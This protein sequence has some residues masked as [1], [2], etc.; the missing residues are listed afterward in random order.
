MIVRSE[1]LKPHAA[2]FYHPPHLSLL[3][4]AM[5]SHAMKYYSATAFL[6]LCLTM[7]PIHSLLQSQPLLPKFAYRS[8]SS[9]VVCHLAPEV[10]TAGVVVVA[11]GAWWLSGSEERDKRAMYAD[12]EQ[13]DRERREER[14]RLAYIEPKETWALEELKA[15]DGKTD[16]DGPILMAVS[17]S[18]FNV[19]KGRHFYGPGC[20]YGIFAGRD[21]TRLLAKQKLE[22]ETLE[23]LAKPLNVAEKASLEAWYW[24]IKNK[25]EVVGKL[26]DSN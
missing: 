11:G 7:N 26:A 16:E 8:P 23:E 20:E 6:L 19:W 14:A 18:V 24:I 5:S 22:E 9:V 3:F 12:W 10:V 25:Y 13:K 1:E 4:M 15:F 2:H 21:A 17:G